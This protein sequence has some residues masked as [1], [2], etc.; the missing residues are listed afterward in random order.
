MKVAIIDL[1]T[2]SLRLDVYE[3]SAAGHAVRRIY[4]NKVMVRLGDGVFETSELLPE[5]KQ[6]TLQALLDFKHL[7]E[8]EGVDRVVGFAT[9][10]MRQAKNS[11]A[12]VRQIKKLTG[13][14]MEVI[15]GKTEAEF[16]AKGILSNE[17]LPASLVALIDIGGGSTEVSIC[18]KKSVIDSFSF[19]LGANRL[20]QMFLHTVPPQKLPSGESPVEALRAYVNEQVAPLVQKK[21][22][23]S[24][25]VVIGSSGTIRAI[26]KIIRKK[27]VPIDPFKRSSLATLIE[28]ML[29]MS[30]EQLLLLP[31]LEAKRVDLILAGCVLL[32]EI[33]K[34]LGCKKVY[35]TSFSLRD[36]ILEAEMERFLAA[37]IRA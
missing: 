2:N 8:A 31:G 30:R 17:V 1:G 25:E 7:I 34:V 22:W 19:D 16:I 6:R 32:D 14:N 24:I 28:E 4:R 27:D 3:L 33:L 18:H 21:N 15:D 26:A 5:A 29:P 11:K 36:G 10:A 12:F 13:F 23:P 37:Q 20:Q 35:T 9:S